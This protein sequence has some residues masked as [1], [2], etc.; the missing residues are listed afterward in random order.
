MASIIAGLSFGSPGS[1]CEALLKRKLRVKTADTMHQGPE[2]SASRGYTACARQ[3]VDSTFVSM[4][5]GTLEGSSGQISGFQS[6][7][8]RQLKGVAQ[9]SKEQKTCGLVKRTSQRT[10]ATSAVVGS[11]HLG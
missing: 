3:A 2:S 6:G 4:S 1:E 8:K 9:E 7:V 11:P 5:C 10:E